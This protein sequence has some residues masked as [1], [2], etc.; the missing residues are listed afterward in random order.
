MYC[1][2]LFVACNHV[3]FVY[4]RVT[5]TGVLW[6]TLTPS[7]GKNSVSDSALA[8]PKP[9]SWLSR[10]VFHVFTFQVASIPRCVCLSSDAA[11]APAGT[12][13]ASVHALL[14]RLPAFETID[15]PALSEK[16]IPLERDVVVVTLQVW[17]ECLAGAS[18]AFAPWMSLL[19]RTGG[20]NLPALWQAGD[21]ETL[22]GTLILN[23]VETCVARAGEERS[24]VEAAFAEVLAQGAEDTGDDTEIDVAR[25]LIWVRGDE[26]KGRPTLAEW[27][28]AR[29]TVQSRAYRVGQRL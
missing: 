9:R 4:R 24:L 19:P 18:S 14:A 5:I 15:S 28:H 20:L 11:D 23:A 10:C 26:M 6:V 7:S 17:M 25:E 21:L 27:L 8:T 12:L 22:K 13:R 3:V 2:S 1:C 16:A 29:C